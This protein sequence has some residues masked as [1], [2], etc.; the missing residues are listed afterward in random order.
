MFLSARCRSLQSL[1]N[2]A[3]LGGDRFLMADER[4][5]NEAAGVLAVLG[6]HDPQAFAGPRE[7][8]EHHA[9]LGF[10]RL[11]RLGPRMWQQLWRH[12]V[13]VVRLQPLGA[14]DGR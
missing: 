12:D 6:P 14:V 10:L 8:D 9:P 5:G 1:E 7:R 3:S 4:F 11:R 13:D 2:S